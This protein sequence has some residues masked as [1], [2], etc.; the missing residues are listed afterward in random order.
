MTAPVC[1][2]F[3][4]TTSRLIHTAQ[5]LV[6]DVIDV[7]A[8]P[9]RGWNIV[10]AGHALYAGGA[11]TTLAA[12]ARSGA[13]CVHA[14]SVGTGP[15]GGLIREALAQ[16]GVTISSPPVTQT[17]TGVCLVFVEPTAE[18]TFITI[19]GA[20]RHISVESLASAAPRPGDYVAVSGYTLQGA[21]GTPLLAWLETLP[22]GVEVVLDPSSAFAELDE[23]TRAAALSA[24]TIWT[25]NAE[26]A[27]AMTGDAD[28]RTSAALVAEHLRPGAMTI[29]RDGPAG[30]TV[31]QNGVTT[32]VP[33]FPQTPRDSNGAGDTHTGVMLAE[34]LA[35]TDP[36]TA[37]R[38]ANAAG[39]IKVTRHGL[40]P[41]P[42]KA[43]IDDFLA[44]Q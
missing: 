20:E 8:L 24:T 40:Q 41:A 2:T 36:V 44:R 9:R 14:G 37:A 6:D 38:R 39:A 25:S 11:V 3:P 13:C 10:A 27:E 30:C 31:H 34:L 5:A 28:M 22:A 4:M 17:D 15:Y 18:R 16:A 29:V 19:Q 42:T 12:A 43:E 33:G 23:A 21:S 7:P 32:V 1:Q 26:E 35:G